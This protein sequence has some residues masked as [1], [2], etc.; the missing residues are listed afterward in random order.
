[1][2]VLCFIES[3]IMSILIL[4][5]VTVEQFPILIDYLLVLSF[6]SIFSFSSGSNLKF[7]SRFSFFSLFVVYLIGFCMSPTDLQIEE[8][9]RYSDS[10]LLFENK[11]GVSYEEAISGSLWGASRY[12]TGC[13]LNRFSLEKPL[14]INLDVKV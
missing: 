7:F 8:L 4:A 10:N 6:I 13:K 2:K 3:A 12:L 1:M 14:P 9:R 5:F 11:L